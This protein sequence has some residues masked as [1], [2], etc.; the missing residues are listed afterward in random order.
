MGPDWESCDE[1]TVR[2]D[3]ASLVVVNLVGA[4]EEQ[5]RTRL[6]EPDDVVSPGATTSDAVGSVLFRV[7]ADL[8]YYRLLP[9]TC[10]SVS[11]KA[12][13]VAEISWWRGPAT[14]MPRSNCSE[15][16][17]RPFG[18]PDM[19]GSYRSQGASAGRSTPER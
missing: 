5:V 18:W 10:L 14:C 12:G 11:T 16:S 6:G 8:R 19:N 3:A 9:H 15:R 4:P 17:N 7:D 1:K 2:R 13:R